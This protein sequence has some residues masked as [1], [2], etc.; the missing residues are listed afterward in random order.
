MAI[1]I[2]ADTASA[3][4]LGESHV[5]SYSGLLA[6]D[7]ATGRTHVPHTKCLISLKASEYSDIADGSLNPLLVE[8]LQELALTGKA[9]TGAGAD[10][11]R[12]TCLALFAGDIDLHQ[13]LF[14]QM[15]QDYD[16]DLPDQGLYPLE[17]GRALIPFEMV[18]MRL[19][20]M[21]APFLA[22]AARCIAIGIP[23][24]VIHA[25]PPRTADNARAKRWC[26]GRL[27]DKALRAKVT[28][29][30]NRIL[31]AEAA[32]LGIPFVS[33]WDVL[34]PEGYLLPKYDLDGVHVT[35]E[36]AAISYLRILEMTVPSA[37]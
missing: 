30:A 10:P 32:L 13:D 6:R 21:L 34:A 16:I 9:G 17:T 20:E 31:A 15:D 23:R 11:G 25:L 1:E 4:L 18:D 8:A 33:T 24:L 5:L 35:R 37:A 28:F 7:S 3:C 27:V 19:K 29:H 12:F 2:I 22:A 14:A 36:A 26:E